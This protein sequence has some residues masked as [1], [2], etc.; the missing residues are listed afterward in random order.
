MP[1][2][3]DVETLIE[4]HGF[5]KAKAD[6]W[7]KY[8]LRYIDA[9]T[10]DEWRYLPGSGKAPV[11][12][13]TAADA[14]NIAVLKESIA[15]FYPGA[16]SERRYN[17][18]GLNEV[19]SKRQHSEIRSVEE[20]AEYYRDFS[21]VSRA[22]LVNQ[23]IPQRDVDLAFKQGIVGDLKVKVENRLAIKEPDRELASNPY[24]VKNV[25]EAAKFLLINQE[26][27]S[28]LTGAS[29]APFTA[30]LAGRPSFEQE[31]RIKVEQME[32]QLNY[33]KARDAQPSRFQSNSSGWQN[34]SSAPPVANRYADMCLFCNGLHRI[35][36]CPTTVEYEKQGRIRRGPDGRWKLPDGAEIVRTG[37]G[38]LRKFVDEVLAQV[39]QKRKDGPPHVQAESHFFDIRSSDF[40]E[41]SS[42]AEQTY[43]FETAGTEARIEEVVDEDNDDV[44][45][46]LRSA[47]YAMGEKDPQAKGIKETLEKRKQR[48]RFDG[49]EIPPRGGRGR[50]AET[51]RVG[52]PRGA[53]PQ[54][55]ES[56]GGL[57]PRQQGGKP[58]GQAT[59]KVTPAPIIPMQPVGQRAEPTKQQ[60]EYKSPIEEGVQKTA[61]MSKVLD[62]PVSLSMR[63][64]L[65]MSFDG[66]KSLKDLTTNKRATVSS[67]EGHNAPMEVHYNSTDSGS[68]KCDGCG[69]RATVL[70]NSGPMPDPMELCRDCHGI[71][72][73]LPTAQDA[74][75]L[76]VVHPI[77]G[78]GLQ[79][80]CVLD[81][82]SSIVA[83]RRDVWAKLGSPAVLEKSIEMEVANGS[84]SNTR[85]MVP[86]LPFNFGGIVVHLQAQVVDNAPWEVLLGRPFESLT[87]LTTQNF[88]NGDT[89]IT[90]SDPVNPERRMVFPTKARSACRKSPAV[91]SAGF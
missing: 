37:P 19:V 69:V 70:F 43:S 36:Q 47:L 78:D 72:R 41:E 71:V 49:V 59:Q 32:Q 21:K 62:A 91:Q 66:R 85:G 16:K 20:L 28:F 4:E 74:Q 24:P 80:E 79:V 26:A 33:Y 52:P 75:S 54:S 15:T 9:E 18:A 56:R 13:G 83:I 35:N 55:Q 90:I 39:Q 3:E 6:D 12:V 31:M 65:A 48:V 45:H 29:S 76:R 46:H 73:H 57:A 84:L 88:E 64:F 77:I 17:V 1:Y 8:V 61:V 10:A 23:K 82:G 68:G 86:N 30:A 51:E 25:F 2:F 53:K 5:D 81:S 60:Y 11:A 34:S 87:R 7:I 27:Q 42:G 89:E 44:Q 38:P 58:P 50:P 67:F 63:E 40:F 14:A 22:L